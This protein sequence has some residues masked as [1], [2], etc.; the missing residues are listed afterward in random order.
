MQL[1][2]RGFSFRVIGIDLPSKKDLVLESGAE[3]FVDATASPADLV[4][5]VQDLTG[6]LGAQAAIVCNNRNDAYDT[7]LQLLKFG[8][9]L[10]C[11]GMPETEL[12]PIKSAAP[13]T[14]IGKL[15]T[16]TSVAVGNR[17]DA[18]EVMEMAAR[19]VVKTKVEVRPMEDLEKTFQEMDERKLLGRVV[20]E[21]K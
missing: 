20:L 6:G 14:L 15:L 1:A 8:G 19:G 2:A 21:L 17:R 7:S 5:Q 13:L 12:V 16:I 11:V 10:V 4:K 3:H 18:Q 9:T